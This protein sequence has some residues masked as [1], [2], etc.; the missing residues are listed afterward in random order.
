MMEKNLILPFLK[1]LSKNNNREWFAEHKNGFVIAKSQMEELVE[2]LIIRLSN[3][4]QTV[5][6]LD[7]KKCVFRIYRDVRFSKNKAPYK[8]NMGAFMVPGGKKS[9][10]AGYY[11]H[12]EPGASFLGGG[13]Y[14]PESKT[15]KVIREEVMY[16]IDV[17]KSIVEDRDFKAVFGEIRGEKLK[18]PPKGFPAD[19]P[20]IEYLKLKS[21]VVMHPLMDEQIIEPDFFDYAAD[22]FMR[23]HPLNQF[24]NRSFN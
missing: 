14:M 21:Y 11:L 22:V 9:G 17:F 8:I 15:L 10:K 7:A 4:D 20:E 18:R 13:I 2:Q 6:S 3:F 16:E 23:M 12:L 24:L 5:G 19:F 1:K